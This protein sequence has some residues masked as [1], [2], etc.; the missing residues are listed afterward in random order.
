MMDYCNERGWN[1]VDS[2]FWNIAK[3]AWLVY[4]KKGKHE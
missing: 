3:H 2:Y 4:I 1:P